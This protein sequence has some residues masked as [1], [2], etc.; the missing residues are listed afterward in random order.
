M[1]LTEIIAVC[2]Q[3]HTKHINKVCACVCVCVCVCVCGQN[4]RSFNAV[5]GGEGGDRSG[6]LKGVTSAAQI[7]GI[8]GSS[9]V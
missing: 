6:V 8:E 3:I 5:T 4:V 2:S 1:L 9:N 7:T